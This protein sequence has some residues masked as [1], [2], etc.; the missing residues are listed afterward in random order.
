MSYE[1]LYHEELLDHY[2]RPRNQGTLE[3]S[4]FS[5]GVFNP[6]CGDQV[7]MQGTLKNGCIETCLFQAKGCV[8]SLASASLV[9]EL[10]KGKKVEVVMNLSKQ[11]ILD[12]V[13][14]QLGPNRLRCALIALEAVQN[15]LKE[16]F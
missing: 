1:N 13:K 3:N 2:K 11:D 10:V 4:D 12:V 8:I 5:A 15:G 14:L 7:L 16:S 9:T 6:L